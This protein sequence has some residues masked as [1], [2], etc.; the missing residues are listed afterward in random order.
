MFIDPIEWGERY[1]YL[2][3]QAT[4]K[5]RFN[6]KL[7]KFLLP[8]MRAF[9]DPCVP[10]GVE[11]A[12]A[13]GGK[14]QKMLVCAFWVL[15]QDPASMMWLTPTKEFSKKFYKSRLKPSLDL[16]EPLQRRLPRGRHQA[17]TFEI[18][19]STGMFHLANAGSIPEISGHPIRYLIIDEEK[20]YK[21][22]MVEYALV[23]TRSKRDLKRWRMSTPNHFEDTIHLAALGGSQDYWHLRCPACFQLHQV[24]WRNIRYL[25]DDLRVDSVWYECPT[26]IGKDSQDK[27]ITCGRK[28]HD[29][30]EDRLDILDR[31]DYVSH[32]P[33]APYPSWVYNVVIP[34]WA[35]WKAAAELWLK[36]MAAKEKGD[37]EPWRRFMNDSAVEPWED[38]PADKTP[39]IVKYPY[40]LKTYHRKADRFPGEVLRGLG[41]DVQQRDLRAVIRGYD[42]AANS[43]LLFADK[44]T[45]FEDLAVL[46]AEFGIES[47]FVWLDSAHQPETVYAACAERGWFAVIGS[48]EM[49]F[50]HPVKNAAGR[51]IGHTQKPYSTV[52]EVWSFKR[53]KNCKL[54]TL[55]TARLKDITAHFRDGKAGVT[56]EI[57][58]DTPEDYIRQV[59]NQFRVE[60]MNEKT[61]KL[62]MVWPDRRQD[63]FFDC[64]YILSAIAV[65]AGVIRV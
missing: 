49:F 34:P 45:T 11:M 17:N 33:G 8:Q 1:F 56:W 15:D 16:C 63:H 54:I 64:E 31:G 6:S 13:Q 24:R 9:A 23:R 21:P 58:T 20:D 28:W 36:A 51:T 38:Q 30:P 3:P 43:K 18:A 5:G 35:G 10:E 26:V 40:E 27:P 29:E 14:T 25:N 19:F 60:R 2:D 57:G 61:K 32:N 44:I 53:G 48:G 41:V 42:A 22:G 59:Y 47:R 7:C 46:Q 62:E 65:V 50:S 55:S 12:C 37:F 4:A 52:R 39:E